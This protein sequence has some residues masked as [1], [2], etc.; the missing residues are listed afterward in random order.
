[1]VIL[2]GFDICN[3]IFCDSS[4]EWDES[5]YPVG[6]VLVRLIH[7]SGRAGGKRDR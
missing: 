4:M 3:I 1:M 7:A 6:Q 2:Y 5:C